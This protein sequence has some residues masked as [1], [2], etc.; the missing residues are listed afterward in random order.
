LCGAENWAFRKVDQKLV[1]SSEMWCRR[2]MEIGWTDR[3]RNEKVLYG[4]QE[5]R[6]VLH[7]VKRSKANWVGHTLRMNRP[8]KHVIEQNKEERMEKK[9]RLGRRRKQLL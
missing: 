5:E 9:G 3:V 1:K 8:L 2:R 7:T 6:T 4:V